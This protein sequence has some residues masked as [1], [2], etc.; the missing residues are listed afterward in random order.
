MTKTSFESISRERLNTATGGWWGGRP[1]FWGGWPGYM[2][3]MNAAA[4]YWNFWSNLAS[5]SS[6]NN[7]SWGANNNATNLALMLAALA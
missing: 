1:N 4:N 5:T 2:G 6:W 7:N 3:Q